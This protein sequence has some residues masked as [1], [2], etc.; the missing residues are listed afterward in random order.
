MRGPPH[1][2]Y[3]RAMDNLTMVQ[4]IYAAYGRG[5]IPAIL[6]RLDEDV[7]WDGGDGPS[8]RLV[9]WM[10]PRQGRAAVPAFFE[11]LQAIDITR[12]E[13]LAFLTDA[14]HVAAVIGID[15][16]VRATGRSMSDDEL[17]LWTFGPDGRVT[18][19]RHYVDAAKQ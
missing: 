19:F 6:E 8:S 11:A 4:E 16:T 14:T 17:H 13:P 3:G 5:D 9:P 10:Q 1:R 12:F 15:A 7:I 2:S 18:A